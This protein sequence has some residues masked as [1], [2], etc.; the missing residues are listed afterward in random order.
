MG[1]D[2]EEIERVVRATHPGV[3]IARLVVSHAA[4]DDGLWFFRANGIEVQ[5]ESP[6]GACPFFLESDAHSRTRWVRSVD[7]AVRSVIEELG[8]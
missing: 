6:D 7:E 5:L 4:D 2:I 8:L 1:S 3:V